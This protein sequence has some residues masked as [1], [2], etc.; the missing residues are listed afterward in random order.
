MQYENFTQ[1]PG[2][3]INAV[4]QRFTTIVNNLKANVEDFPY[5]EHDQALKLL[6]ILDQ[7]VWSA[8]VGV[9]KE[10]GQYFTIELDDFFSKLKSS[11]V[12]KK[13]Q[14][15]HEGSTDHSLALEGGSKG[16]ANTNPSYQQFSLSSLISIPDEEFNVLGEEELALLSRRFDRLHENRRNARRSSGTCYKCGER[17]HFIAECLEAEENK[18]KMSEYKAHPRREDKYSSKGRH[19][20]K[21]KSKDKARAMVAG[22]SDVNS[23]SSDAH[24]SSSSEDEDA[25]RR[26]GNKNASRNLSGLSCVALG[27][28]CGMAQSSR[29]KKGEKEDT[30]SDS[31][32][33]VNRDPDSLLV[34][35]TRLNGLIDNCDSLLRDAKKMRIN[36]MAQLENATEKVGESES[37]LL[38]L[39][40]ENDSLKLTPTI[41]DDVGCP[42]CDAWLNE[43]KLLNEK[44]ASTLTKL[45]ALRTE[46]DELKARPTLLGACKSCPTMHAKLV[47]ARY[48]IST[49]EASLK[50]PVVNACTSCDE[51]TLRNL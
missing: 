5:T 13:L 15:K 22:A 38:E 50:S 45:D 8:K 17:G 1:L 27:G 35:I 51:V 4:F 42:E 7:N 43:I 19:Y 47:D 41:C 18:Y 9:I 30:D 23:S 14:S 24:S 10:Y 20:S 49:L 21:S 25:E 6:H 40:L 46:Y 31:E 28:I 3:D 16:K 48:T 12:D 33:E 32:D 2:E 36:L 37:K 44:N 26:K 11:E 39:K 34:E 29:S